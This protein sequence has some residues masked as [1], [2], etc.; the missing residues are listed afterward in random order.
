MWLE[1]KWIF[2]LRENMLRQVSIK[3]IKKFSNKDYIIFVCEWWKLCMGCLAKSLNTLIKDLR[4]ENGHI[5]YFL[6]YENIINF[7][8]M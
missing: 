5:G 6:H 4:T 8:K 3:M 7:T 1:N 2:V